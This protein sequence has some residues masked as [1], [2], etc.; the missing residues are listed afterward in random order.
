MSFF[1]GGMIY[2]IVF[3]NRIVMEFIELESRLEVNRGW[4]MGIGRSC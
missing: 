1:V 4:E 2:F 3:C